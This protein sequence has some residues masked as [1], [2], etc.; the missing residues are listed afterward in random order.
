MIVKGINDPHDWSVEWEKDMKGLE[1]PDVPEEV[2]NEVAGF[3]KSEND[4]SDASAKR[5]P[6]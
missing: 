5:V 6:A 1:F 3:E 4:Q 2:A